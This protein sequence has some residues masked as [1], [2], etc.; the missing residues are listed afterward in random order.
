MEHNLLGVLQ[1]IDPDKSFRDQD[2]DKLDKLRK[3]QTRIEK[4]EKRLNDCGKYANWY[5]PHSG[6]R[7][8][9]IFRCGLFRHCSVCLKRRADEEYTWVKQAT[10]D[11]RMIVISV[12]SKAATNIIRKA[13]KTEYIR[14]P[15]EDG[16][17][18]LFLDETLGI[19]GEAVD[20]DWVVKQDWEIIVSTPKG[21]NKSGTMHMPI[22]EDAGEEFTIINTQQ[23]ITNANRYNTIKA[24]KEAEEQTANLNPKTANE[25]V[26]AL[27]KRTRIATRKLREMGYSINMYN[28]KL[29][30]IHSMINWQSQNGN[31]KR[32]HTEN[33]TRSTTLSHDNLPSSIIAAQISPPNNL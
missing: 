12:D 24:M 17:D 10:L 23:F 26:N 6:K 3:E 33:P 27:R 16:K 8:G 30:L 13:E 7:T 21:R 1:Q 25:V 14:F 15:G 31:I 18:L 19:V 32:L 20:L 9:F 11:K 5:N 28:K 2:L 4:R 22:E 29:K